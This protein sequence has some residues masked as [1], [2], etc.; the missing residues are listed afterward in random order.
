[1]LKTEQINKT[2]GEMTGLVYLSR[3]AEPYK[4]EGET[5]QEII[6]KADKDGVLWIAVGGT[7]IGK[8][9]MGTWA[10]S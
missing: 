9:I 8:T 7:L 3:T 10:K 1:M 5:T 6:D 4:L 2:E